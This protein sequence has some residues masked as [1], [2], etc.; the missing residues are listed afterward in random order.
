MALSELKIKALKPTEKQYRV[1][2]AEGLY[3]MIKPSGSKLWRYN[4]RLGGKHRTLS[5]GQYPIV[6]LAAARRARDE[7]KEMVR[8]G[9]DPSKAK[10]REERQEGSAGNGPLFREIADRWFQTNREQWVSSYYLRL[11][12]RMVEDVYPMLGDKPISDITPADVLTT[13]RLIEARGAIETGRRIRQM[14]S[15]VFQFAIPDGHVTSDPARDITASL[16]PKKRKKRR[17]FL[18]PS[19]MPSLIEKI[20]TYDGEPTTRLGLNFVAHTI[21]RTDELRRATWN[22]I[23]DLDGAR[24][25]WRIPAVRM[26]VKDERKDHLVP[27]S[28][29]AVA[30]LKEAESYR[31]G[32]L[33]FPSMEGD[34]PMSQN[35]LIYAIYRLG[36]RSRATVHGFRHSASTWL[37][38]QEFNSDAIELQLAHIDDSVRGVYN[39]AQYLTIR[40][41]FMQ[42][43]SD[44]IEPPAPDD[45]GPSDHAVPEAFSDL[46]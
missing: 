39:N 26:K 25:L 30:V 3:L 23:E 24:P 22:E 21:V 8:N 27:L 2:D 34:K 1:T 14:I 5:I 17:A 46:L 38:E 31:Q 37:N 28:R 13:I 7:A 16:A 32:D 45:P 12:N 40:R 15:K 20:R 36:Y 29:Q 9:V 10:R 35:T 18:L 19:E 44:F 42:A 4:Y 6:T 43:W 41:E 33:I 11:R